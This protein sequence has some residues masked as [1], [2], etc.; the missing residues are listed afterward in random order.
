MTAKVEA[1]IRTVL[2]TVGQ[3]LYPDNPIPQLEGG[4]IFK[5]IADGTGVKEAAVADIAKDMGMWPHTI[6]DI[7]RQC[8]KV[9]GI[10]DPLATL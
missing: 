7:E 8:S 2:G 3:E 5:E 10:G 9:N 4:G 1:R 6:Y